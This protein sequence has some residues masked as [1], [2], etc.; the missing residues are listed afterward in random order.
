MIVSRL[1][2]TVMMADGGERSDGEQYGR[3]VCPQ[4]PAWLQPAHTT[5]NSQH[6]HE[7][8][9]GKEHT[10]L[11]PPESEEK[12]SIKLWNQIAFNIE[13]PHQSSIKSIEILCSHPTN[14]IF[15]A[16]KLSDVSVLADEA[17]QKL[18]QIR[19]SLQVAGVQSK[20]V[21]NHR[22]SLLLCKQQP[23]TPICSLAQ[24]CNR[25]IWCWKWI[26]ERAVW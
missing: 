17:L 8:S 5:V 16:W 22:Y 11:L 7:D 25:A 23:T 2:L 20:I 3:P 18:M 26:V 9:Q 12:L 19:L 15:Q 4:P 14:N 10:P 21:Y 1:R 24:R 6:H 13:I